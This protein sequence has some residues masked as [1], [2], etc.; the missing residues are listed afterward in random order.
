ME[1]IL[2]TIKDGELAMEAWDT[3]RRV[4]QHSIVK[5]FDRWLADLRVI[6]DMTNEVD[7]RKRVERLMLI[8]E[9]ELD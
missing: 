6:R 4:S 5:K 2:D 1:K 7:T 9:A 3:T 8:L